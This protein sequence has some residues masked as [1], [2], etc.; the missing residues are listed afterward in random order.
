MS[1]PL[2][3]DEKAIKKLAKILKETDLNE[4]EYAHGDKRIKVVHTPYYSAGSSHNHSLIPAVN[5]MSNEAV[6]TAPLVEKPLKHPG[7]VESPMV[8]TAYLSAEPGSAPFVSL[9]QAVNQG[10]TLLI[11]ESMKVMNPIRAPRSGRVLQ[12][13]VQNAS[14]VEFGEVLVIIE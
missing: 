1:E 5:T 11:V 8:G 10:D 14:P 9:G 2:I 13:L 12:I 6:P 3:I 7:A 4:I